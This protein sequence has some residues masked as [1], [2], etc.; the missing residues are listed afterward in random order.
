MGRKI[1][2]TGYSVRLQV[3]RFFQDMEGLAEN[4]DD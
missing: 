2:S 1:W 4:E 3:C